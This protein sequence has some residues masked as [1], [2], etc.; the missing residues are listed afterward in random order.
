MKHKSKAHF[1]IRGREELTVEKGKDN[2]R[3]EQ[4]S[5]YSPELKSTYSSNEYLGFCEH[6]NQASNHESEDA[7]GSESGGPK[8][9]L[10]TAR[11][12]AKVLTTPKAWE[13]RDPPPPSS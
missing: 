1:A 3:K 2:E 6:R 10:P 4:A 9:S 11:A 5:R 12:T 7:C 13:N 8:G